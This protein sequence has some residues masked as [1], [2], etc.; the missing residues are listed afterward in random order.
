MGD[1]DFSTDWFFV[2]PLRLGSKKNTP[3]VWRIDFELTPSDKAEYVLRV[4]IA[5]AHQTALTIAL[6]DPEVRDP[7]FDSGIIGNDNALA[8]A[9]DHG[10]YFELE[11]RIKGS[12]LKRGVNSI[13]LKQRVKTSYRFTHIM[14]DYL[15]MEGPVKE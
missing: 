13:F 4:A 14:Y 15:R 6:N 8:R 1:S 9:S 7:I 5:A 3:T 2:Q 12:D 10:D 11:V